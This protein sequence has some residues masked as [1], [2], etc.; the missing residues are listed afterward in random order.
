VT[1]LR[2]RLPLML[3]LLRAVGPQQLLLA[4]AAG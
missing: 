3:W 2:L 4:V 1:F